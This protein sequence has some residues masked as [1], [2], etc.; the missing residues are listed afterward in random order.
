MEHKLI[1]FVVYAVALCILYVVIDRVNNK[2][3]SEKTDSLFYVVKIPDA[4]S[5]VY[6]AFFLM[7]LLLFAIFLFFKLKGNSSITT[8]NF[9]FALIISSIG[10][11]VMIWASKWHIVVNNGTLEIYRMFHKTTTVQASQLDHVEI[12]KKSELILYSDGKKLITIDCLCD[13]YDLLAED[14]KREGK[15]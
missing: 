7:G 10:L 1:R 3:T 15:L 4:L 5:Y 2:G 6:L 13:N 14:L 12:G 9:V 8:G 11:L